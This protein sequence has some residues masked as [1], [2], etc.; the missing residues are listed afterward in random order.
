ML[1]LTK[2]P[3]NR[4]AEPLVLWVRGEISLFTPGPPI[5]Y[6]AACRP[7]NEVPWSDPAPPSKVK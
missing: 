2:V 5:P 4:A 7:F 3:Q 6:A 1:N